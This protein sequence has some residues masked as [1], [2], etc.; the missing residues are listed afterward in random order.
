MEYSD[1]FDAEAI[2]NIFLYNFDIMSD[3][4]PSKDE[5]TGLIRSL[6]VLKVQMNDDIAGFLIIFVWKRD[7][8]V[9]ELENH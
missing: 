6:S 3:R 5:L 9:A 8:G 1:L 2:M 7:I 4:I